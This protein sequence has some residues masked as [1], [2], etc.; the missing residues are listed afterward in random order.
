LVNI[1]CFTQNQLSSYKCILDLT[2]GNTL[3]ESIEEYFYKDVVSVA[4]KTITKTIEIQETLPNGQIQNNTRQINVAEEFAL[5]TSAGISIS[6]VIS[7]LSIITKL[8]GGI[9]PTTRAENAI[10]VIRKMLREKKA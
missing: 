1:I 5:T 3:N 4:K 9:L 8:G 2:T 10:K 6:I 7:D